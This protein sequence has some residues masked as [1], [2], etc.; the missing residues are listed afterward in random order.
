MCIRDRSTLDLLKKLFPYRSCTKPITG[1]DP[2]PCLDY[3]IKRCI[4]PCTSYCSREEYTEVVS[5]IIMFLEGKS[6]TVL[7]Q[8]QSQ[9]QSAS[10]SMDYERAAMLRFEVAGDLNLPRMGTSLARFSLHFEISAV[11]ISSRVRSPN[12]E[13]HFRSWSA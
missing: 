11:L 6:D 5:Q 7:K 1:N 2:R 8:L 4:A 12:N 3:Y 13:H 10:N 9:M